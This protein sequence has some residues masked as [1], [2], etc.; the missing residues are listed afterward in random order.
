MLEKRE[1]KTAPWYLEQ[2][3]EEFVYT[4]KSPD[5]KKQAENLGFTV[6]QKMVERLGER[7]FFSKR[8]TWLPDYEGDR[9]TTVWDLYFADLP[10]HVRIIVQDDNIV[11]DGYCWTDAEVRVLSALQAVTGFKARQCSWQ[12][13]AVK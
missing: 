8:D 13:R 10:Q 4:P 12:L 2:E 3:A 5:E 1:A 9:F 11:L 6:C 7:V